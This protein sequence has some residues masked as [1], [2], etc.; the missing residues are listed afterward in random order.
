MAAGRGEAVVGDEVGA[1]DGEFCGGAG[2]G[3]VGHEDEVV[4]VLRVALVHARHER[5]EGVA[6]GFG[7]ALIDVVDD[8]FGEEGEHGFAIAGVEGGVVA[9]EGFE[10]GRVH[11]WGG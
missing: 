2:T 1:V 5:A 4:E 10:G 7:V 11:G 3:S 8:V 9:L 6:A